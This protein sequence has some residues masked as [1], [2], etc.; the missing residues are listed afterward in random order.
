MA[1]WQKVNIIILCCKFSQTMIETSQLKQ[2]FKFLLVIF[3]I[4][5]YYFT[6]LLIKHSLLR[7]LPCIADLPSKST[8]GDTDK[9]EDHVFVA[10]ARVFSGTV[11][12][13]QK[14]YVL[15][16]K[17][18]PAKALQEVGVKKFVLSNKACVTLSHLTDWKAHIQRLV[19][20]RNEFHFSDVHGAM[21]HSGLC[22]Q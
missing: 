12:Q 17:H 18:D 5:L 4:S 14:L 20:L 3:F 22:A 8:D 7:V 9:G 13:G 19:Y 16:P 6:Y 1:A 10:F 11:R 2:N 21:N 15:G